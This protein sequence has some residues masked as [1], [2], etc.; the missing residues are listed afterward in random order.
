MLTTFLSD[1]TEIIVGLSAASATVLAAW[2][3][4]GKF[5]SNTAPITS[6]QNMSNIRLHPDD[7]KVLQEIVH[8]LEEIRREAIT[9]EGIITTVDK[10]VS[11]LLDR[12]RK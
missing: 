5:R 4:R 9:R 7:L 1:Y 2:I 3:A 11:I 8:Q 10:N 6:K 12:T